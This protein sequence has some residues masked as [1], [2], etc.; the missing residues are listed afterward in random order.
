LESNKKVAITHLAL[1]VGQKYYFGDDEGRAP[2]LVTDV[3]NFKLDYSS[4]AERAVTIYEIEPYVRGMSSGMPPKKPRERIAVFPKF[5]A[6]FCKAVQPLLP[7]APG[8]RP[9][10]NLSGLFMRT[11]A[12][13]SGYVHADFGQ[14]A[15]FNTTDNNQIYFEIT[16][17]DTPD[18]RESYMGTRLWY[19]PS[20]LSKLQ[21]I[22]PPPAR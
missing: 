14:M 6:F 5:G 8:I 16:M 15:T 21:N 9:N 3:L 20:E 7:E 4:A 18:K 11:A 17:Q 10:N 2:I 12:G 22:L 1:G 19:S 13:S